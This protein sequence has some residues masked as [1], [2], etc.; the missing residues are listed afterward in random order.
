MSRKNIFAVW[1]AFLSTVL[2]T[3]YSAPAKSAARII[4]VEITSGGRF[5]P[6]KIFV[7]QDEPIIFVVTA[8]K[9]KDSTWPADVLHGFYLMYDSAILI[10]ETVQVQNPKARKATIRV[11]WTP[12]FEA[13]FTLRCPYHQHSFGRVIVKQ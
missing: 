9:S 7:K 4:R 8:H 3:P 11:E 13:E 1:F 10:K 2:L 6:E 12:R 5:V